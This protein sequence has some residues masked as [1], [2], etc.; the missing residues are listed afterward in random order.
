LVALVFGVVFLSLDRKRVSVVGE[1]SLSSLEFYSVKITHV[2]S[3]A[4]EEIQEVVCEEVKPIVYSNLNLKALRPEER[5]RAFINALLPSALIANYRVYQERENILR[6]L[7]KIKGGREITELEREFLEYM[8]VKYRSQ[9]V[10]ELIDKVNPVPVSL[11]LAQAAIETGWGTS[12]AFRVANNSFGMWTFNDRENHIRVVGTNIKLRSFDNILES[13]ENYIY[14]LNV[15]W[16]YREFRNKRFFTFDS[17][18][19]AEA[20]RYY[21]VQRDRYVRKIKRVI[22]TNDLKRYD[23]C[24]LNRDYI[25]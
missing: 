25:F 15:G 7:F 20:L 12:R 5:K 6:I 9:S 18:Q 14:T 24:K 19:L 8:L 1:H 21:S 23:R 16:A 2:R 22:Q 13:V 4:P 11:I 10:E 3:P 17:L